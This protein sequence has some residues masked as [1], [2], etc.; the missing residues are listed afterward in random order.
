MV[1]V[2][3]SVAVK[4]VVDEPDGDVAEALLEQRL[5]APTL[6]LAEAANALWSKCRRKH[7]TEQE[8]HDACRMLVQAPVTR[9]ERSAAADSRPAGFGR[10]A[11]DL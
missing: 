2:D 6:W 4:W 3:A 10:R 1:I 8:V 9:I 11:S 7:I 5:A